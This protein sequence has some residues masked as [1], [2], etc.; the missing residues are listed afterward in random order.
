[1]SQLYLHRYL[2][3][4]T[5]PMAINSGGREVGFDTQ[6][7]RDA[8]GLPIIPATALAG[9]W[10]HLAQA[11]L[12]EEQAKHWFGHLVEEGHASKLFIQNAVLVDENSTPIIGLIP[13]EKIENS[14]YLKRLHAHRP[15]HRER[16]RINDRGVASD[17][18]K[19]D[20]ILLPKGVRF[21]FDVRWQGTEEDAEAW[22]AL[23]TLLAH[24]LFA[25]GA[26][27][28]N[29]LGRFKIN[30]AS[31]QQL[32]LL[33]N[34]EA[35]KVLQQFMQRRELPTEP[36]HFSAQHLT[37]FA[38]LAL[39]AHDAWRSGTG[40][41][42]IGQADAHT[43]TFTYSE[44]VITW[45]NNKATW[46]ST[47]QVVLCGSSIKGILAHRLAYH[48]RRLTAQ[49][50][51]TMADAS[52]DDW[53]AMPEELS[54]LLG[55]A[56]DTPEESQAG[57]LIVP[58]VVI[59]NPQPFVRTYN[60]IDRFTGG[61]QMGALF[62]EELLWQPEFVVELYLQ[63]HTQ[64]SQPLQQALE[65]TLSDLEHGLLPLG[66]GRNGSLVSR[67]PDGPWHIDSSQIHTLQE[68]SA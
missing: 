29:G 20:Q 28:R 61:V 19:F 36:P 25:L 8:N 44:P 3:E 49:W 9:V 16:V 42:P 7:A 31:A 14:P 58:D 37:P 65:A 34:P 55:K 46:S 52:H 33:G 10:R 60:R 66:S 17:K 35:G 1:M 24:P 40:S 4:T 48:Y 2:L 43:D 68:A 56:G 30:A 63:P 41:R 26:S 27:T 64:L 5:A 54:Q 62:S 6:L 59:Q 15:H 39:K 51:E 50:A 45:E 13:A 11:T 38:T 32:P 67:H 53:Q 47:P 22:K 12:G 18:G 21:V 57:R 23:E